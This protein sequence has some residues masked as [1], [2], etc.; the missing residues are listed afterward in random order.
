[1]DL[2]KIANNLY[3]Q[4]VVEVQRDF[5]RWYKATALDGMSLFGDDD[6]VSARESTIPAVYLGEADF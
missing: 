4:P 2:E 5:I 1:M 3:T 6:E